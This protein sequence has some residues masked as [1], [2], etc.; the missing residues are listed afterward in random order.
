VEAEYERGDETSER[1]PAQL[2]EL[3]D[4]ESACLAGEDPTT[5]DLEDVEH[6]IDVYGELITTTHDLLPASPEGSRGLN[7][8]LARMRGRLEFWLRRRAE[9]TCRRAD[10]EA[11]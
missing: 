3:G 8:Q 1:R 7:E 5:G 10:T 9:L 4:V 11:S 6:W 2:R